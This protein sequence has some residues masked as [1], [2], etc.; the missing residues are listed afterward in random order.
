MK[1]PTVTNTKSN[2]IILQRRPPSDIR[3]EI[4]RERFERMN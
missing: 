4:E 1:A 2:S 3:E